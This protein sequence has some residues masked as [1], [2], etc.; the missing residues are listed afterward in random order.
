MATAVF[1]GTFDPLHGGHLGQLLRA[2][3]AIPLSKVLI[4]VDKNPTHKPNASPWQHRLKMAELTLDSF[5]LP[6]KHD[7]LP[8]NGSLA[9]EVTEQIDYKITGID[10]LIENIADPSRW[11]FIN[12]WPMIVLSIPG[13]EESTLAQAVRSAPDELRNNLRYTYINETKAPMMNYDFKTQTFS[14]NR[15]HATHL[16]SGD[17]TAH[18]PARV[19]EY[20]REHQLYNS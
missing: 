17:K 15:V 4:L 11:M 18:I 1:I 20:I 2:N 10:S 13:I 8:V 5:D 16:R 7:V 6:F 12:K 14:Q 19:Q 3:Y 9:N